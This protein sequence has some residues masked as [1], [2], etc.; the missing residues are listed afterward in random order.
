MKLMAQMASHQQAFLSKAKDDQFLDGRY[1]NLKFNW[2]NFL[3]NL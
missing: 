3:K 2:K 1:K